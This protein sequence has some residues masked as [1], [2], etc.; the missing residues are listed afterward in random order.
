MKVLSFLFVIAAFL[1]C[2]ACGAQ[3]ASDGPPIIEHDRV[4]FSNGRKVRFED[5]KIY[6]QDDIIRPVMDKPVTMVERAIV[7]Q[8]WGRVIIEAKYAYFEYSEI[9]FQFYDFKGKLLR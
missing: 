8:E 7:V 6:L 1:A 4:I 5:D 3:S 9:V 2:S